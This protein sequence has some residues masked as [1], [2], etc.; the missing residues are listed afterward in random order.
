MPNL[1]N[2]ILFL[3]ISLV[4]TTQDFYPKDYF[5]SPVDIPIMLA[6]NFGEIRAGHFHAGLDIKTEGVEGKNI[7]AAADG[8]VARIKI[9][10]GGY[11]KALYLNHPNGYSTT[12]A[13]LKNFSPELEAAI[14]KAQYQKKS[15][16]I[17]LFFSSEEFVVKKGEVIAKSGNTGG[18]GGPHLHFEIRETEGE[19]PVNPIHFGFDIK[20]NVKPIIKKLGI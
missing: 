10:H 11:G 13:H 15:Y 8:Y 12:Y 9:S 19:I 1:L 20:D 14:K 17:E 7:Y 5:R 18:S 3:L 4:G 2:I 16:E 6:G